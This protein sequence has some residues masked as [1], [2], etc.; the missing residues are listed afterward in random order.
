MTLSSA[1]LRPRHPLI[2]VYARR[3]DITPDMTYAPPDLAARRSLDSL[4]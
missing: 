1:R 3:T 2:S 4:T